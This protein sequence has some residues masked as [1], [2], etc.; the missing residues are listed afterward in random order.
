MRLPLTVYVALSRIRAPRWFVRLSWD[1]HR[2]YKLREDW[3]RWIE[4]GQ[5]R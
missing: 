2:L 3:G 4:E 1:H 5:W